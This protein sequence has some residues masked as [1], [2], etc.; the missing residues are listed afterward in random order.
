[1][2]LSVTNLSIP[3]LGAFNKC[4]QPLVIRL[5]LL[6]TWV[7]LVLKRDFVENDRARAPRSTMLV[8]QH[9]NLLS[10]G[11]SALKDHSPPPAN[12]VAACCTM[13]SYGIKR[14]R[15]DKEV[16]VRHQE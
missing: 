15:S 9:T 11:A 1:M 8:D 4:L 13:V 7:Y 6:V 3:R 14:G 5:Q 2:D 12:C 10:L 16:F